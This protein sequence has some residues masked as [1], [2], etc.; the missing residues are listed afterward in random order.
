MDG[1]PKTIDKNNIENILSLSPV[2]EGILFHYLLN[3]KS[4]YYLEQLRL[5]VEGEVNTE[6]F[7]RA[8]DAVVNANEMLRTV[9]RWNNLTNPVQ[10]ILKKNE[11]RISFFD[12]TEYVDKEERLDKIIAEDRNDFF[13]LTEVPFSV[14]LCKLTEKSYNIII[15]HHH[16]LY[17]GWSTG[18]ILR[19]FFNAYK[20]LADNKEIRLNN[21]Q[22]YHEY[23][24]WLR[25]DNKKIQQDFWGEYLR[26][27]SSKSILD[28]K[29][30]NETEGEKK[31]T[32][33]F[34]SLPEELTEKIYDFARIN[35]ITAASL[36]YSAWGVLLFNYCNDEDIAFGTTTAVRPADIKNIENTVGLFINTIPL[37]IKAT[38]E[39]NVLSY[40]KNVSCSLQER[41]E[42]E[43]TPLVDIKKY[44]ELHR[45]EELFQS[46]FVIENYP[47]DQSLMSDDNP[48]RIKEYSSFEKTN[49]DLTIIVNLSQSAMDIKLLYNCELYDTKTIQNLVGHY[50]VILRELI[51][52]SDCTLGSLNILTQGE[53]EDILHLFNDTNSVYNDELLIHEI[54]E[55]RVEESPDCV[56]VEYGNKKITYFELNRR[57]NQ[58]ARL[59]NKKVNTAPDSKIG[60]LLYPSLEMIIGVLAILKTGSAYVPIDPD[61]PIDRN[62]FII[63]DSKICALI[64]TSEHS[65]KIDF[66]GQLIFIDKESGDGE[67]CY[68]PERKPDSGNLAYMIY[69]SGSTGYPKGVMVEHKSV[70]NILL[71]LEKRYPLEETDTY[72]LKTTFTFDVSVTELFGWF[73]GKGKLVILNKGEE[74]NPYKIIDAVEAFG[75]T[76]LNLVPSMFRYILESLSQT[77]ENIR[78]LKSLKYIF[79]AGEALKPDLVKQFKELGTDIRLENIYGPTECTIYATKYSLKD[80]Q[81]ESMVPI[82]TPLSNIRCYIVDKHNRL[83]PVGVPGELCLSGVGL[84]RGYL[85]RDELNKEK[86]VPNPF[87]TEAESSN[88]YSATFQKMYKTGDLACWLPDGNIECLGRNDFQVKI[89]G[90]RIELEEI[91]NKLLKYEKIMEA[92]VIPKSDREGNVHLCAYFTSGE[93]VTDSEINNFLS[94]ELP[95]YMLPSYFIRLEKMPLTQSGKI[96]RK[97]LP[98]RNNARPNIETKFIEPQTEI[99]REIIDIWKEVLGIEKIGINDNFFDIGGNS[100]NLIRLNNKLNTYFKKELPITTIFQF[101]TVRGLALSLTDN[102]DKKLSSTETTGQTQENTQITD[103]APETNDIAIIGMSVR[104]PNISDIYEYWNRLVNST[105]CI[106]FFTEEEIIKAGVSPKLA[107]DS[108]YV[109]AQG[110][111]NGIENFDA[112]FFSYSPRE[113]EVMDPQVRVFHE[114]IWE[115]L[116]DSGYCPW[117][118]EGSIGLF[119]SASPNLFWESLVVGSGKT[120]ILGDFASEQLFNKDYMSTRVAY[121]LNLTGPVVSTYSACSTS[122]VSVALACQSLIRKECDISIAGSA[123]ISPLPDKTGYLYQDGMVK[124]P[125]GHCRAFDIDGKGFVGGTGSAAV[126]LK[127][128]DDAVKCK[129]NIIA[130]IKAAEINNDGINKAGYTAPSIDGQKKVIQAALKRTGI[131]PESISYIEAHGT[132][133]PLGDSVEIEALKQAFNT[134][135][136]N[137]CGIGSVK[138]N[139]GHLDCTAGI[140]GL[141]KTAL[142]L[143]NKIIP[144][145]LNITA[146]NPK[147]NLIDSPFYLVTEP[148]E[149]KS[150]EYPLRAGVSSLGLGGTNAHVI[151]EEAPE[152]KKE[153]GPLTPELLLFSGKTKSALDNQILRIRKHLQT[154]PNLDLNDVGYTLQTGRYHFNHR[155]AF[156]CKDISEAIKNLGNDCDLSGYVEGEKTLITFNFQSTD[157]TKIIRYIELYESEPVFKGALDQVIKRLELNLPSWFT[158][159]VKNPAKR[160]YDKEY[161]NT[162]NVFV[163]FAMQYALAK[164]LVYWGIVPDIARYDGEG[165]LISLLLAQAAPE[166]SLFPLIQL[167]LSMIDNMGKGIECSGTIHDKF[168]ELLW[169]IEFSEP[170]IQCF[171]IQYGRFIN[172]EDFK[173]LA[174]WTR[175]SQANTQSNS[176]KIETDGIHVFIDFGEG[177]VNKPDEGVVKLAMC[178][179]K[180]LELHSHVLWLIGQAWLNGIKIKWNRFYHQKERKR[181]SLPTYPFEHQKYWIEGNPFTMELQKQDAEITKKTDISDWFYLPL[182]K[183]SAPSILN[184]T[185]DNK[186][187]WLVFTNSVGF[188]NNLLKAL[189]EKTEDVIKVTKGSDFNKVDD[190]E[191]TINVNHQEDYNNLLKELEKTGKLPSNILFLWGID[192][193]ER[194]NTLDLNSIYEELDTGFFSLVYIS[195]ALLRQSVTDKVRIIVA[196]N[197]LHNING[198]ERINPAKSTVLGPCKVIP[199]EAPFIECKNIDICIPKDEVTERKLIKKVLAD[200]LDEKTETVVAYRNCIRYTQSYSQVKLTQDAN[201]ENSS[202]KNN[203]V[204][205]I[206]GGLGNIGLKLA[207]YLAEKYS[208]KLIL[209]GKS[210]FPRRDKWEQW[211]DSHSGDEQ[212]SMK[213]QNLLYLEK[214]GAKILT[215]TCDVADQESMKGIV[216]EAE[217]HFGHI[218]GV[219]HAAATMRDSL[220]RTVEQLNKEDCIEQFIPKI[221]GLL[222]LHKV[223]KDREL[224]F[225]TVTSSTSALLG[226]LGFCAY[227]A[228]NIFMDSFVNEF[229]RD[230]SK[231]W[232][233]VNWEGWR[234]NSDKTQFSFST[235]LDELLMEPEQGVEA[236]ERIMNNPGIGQVIISS[237]DL[238]KRVDRWIKLDSIKSADS[239][240]DSGNSKK[241]RPNLK[242]SYVMPAN[243]LEETIAKVFADFFG[244]DEIGIDDNFFDLGASSLDMIQITN[245][246]RRQLN[247]NIPILKLFTFSTIR[248]LAAN[249][250]NSNEDNDTQEINQQRENQVV[251]GKNSIQARYNLR[252]Q[253][254]KKDM[255]DD[256][257]D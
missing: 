238:N 100:L 9:F 86:F 168:K 48:L 194:I 33:H 200:I 89:R 165:G 28:R 232:L 182:W 149:W 32:G 102:T 53:K 205:L 18:I 143:K 199:Q 184:G 90:F 36:L 77:K 158:D 203:G 179:T 233:T 14:A 71:D 257:E 171:D 195:K 146:A 60:I 167:R 226:G 213:I 224:D 191:Y 177:L 127:R 120:K 170:V 97:L 118:Y 188:N 98:E 161:L 151:L 40:I 114:I 150:E 246:L 198:A 216:D 16:I 142:A 144:S 7:Q 137:Y 82:G 227:S 210:E 112:D 65:Q 244:Y 185:D 124:S 192:D 17:D 47:I 39:E 94:G 164:L 176:S 113:A 103:E 13:D 107:R 248:T 3:E 78:K 132:A 147:L 56:A 207:E 123:T 211:V 23:I 187:T 139:I 174:F 52:K 229:N 152:V 136:K 254:K 193:D 30:I 141:I 58:L 105:E 91:E 24:K 46:I 109:K 21:K 20:C 130:V 156:V 209:T 75:V 190:S 43:A 125:D 44:S 138:S 106:S 110:V 253:L 70:V 135:M 19:D 223:F 80:H 79:A 84:A 145:T 95:Y 235:S 99:Q 169:D 15:T 12:L 241:Q 220:F 178:C 45:E 93:E 153:Q 140:A 37:R 2:Q 256:E 122:L 202:F 54:F 49:Y 162:N 173:N 22:K 27:Y 50:E 31:V 67:N 101:P 214:Q 61:N 239:F 59:I 38:S 237:G 242:N 119:G 129:D 243:K 74:K 11:T 175:D 204:Y 154:N 159:M 10:I 134:P 219:I 218:D 180:D 104:L 121:K 131:S 157:V 234:F 197:N 26:N 231:E 126:V 96:D 92:V 249:L 228:A 172:K 88:R 133:T 64:S 1:L 217:R 72:L 8:W 255:A 5:R 63:D 34:F 163:V 230:A 115:A 250:Q 35:N 251:K 4:S 236:F 208:A 128:L 181:V 222:T 66:D 252:K 148:T 155:K 189:K 221:H 41:K 25:A 73:I 87:I 245:N 62:K 116:E 215:Y 108:N 42:Y 85:N 111:M 186:S 183:Q 166:D 247:T 212:I 69:T 81:N 117:N 55:K 201:R 6:V 206:T 51:E 76:H 29:A 160:N 83:Q 240:N 68:N 57:V 225:L 196:T